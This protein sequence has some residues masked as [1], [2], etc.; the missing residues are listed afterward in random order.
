MV[1][2]TFGV[3]VFPQVLPFANENLSGNSF[4][5]RWHIFQASD[6]ARRS[7]NLIYLFVWRHNSYNPGLHTHKV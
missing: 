2:C 7:V 6:A 1:K 5:T 4:L 3:N